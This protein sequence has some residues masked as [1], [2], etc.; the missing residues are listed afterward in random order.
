MR[1][2]EAYLQIVQ[3]EL[4]ENKL[5]QAVAGAVVAGSL[6][7][8]IH[9]VLKPL[10]KQEP[11]SQRAITGEVAKEDDSAHREHELHHDGS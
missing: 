6:L 8:G 1:L 5:T 2:E 4:E 11:T 10:A 3:Q 7:A 9:H